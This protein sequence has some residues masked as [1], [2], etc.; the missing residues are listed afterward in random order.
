MAL[1]QQESLVAGLRHQ[2]AAAEDAIATLEEQLEAGSGDPASPGR[3]RNSPA[4][5]A[6]GGRG[7]PGLSDDRA[8]IAAARTRESPLRLMLLAA[9]AANQGVGVGTAVAVWRGQLDGI[10]D[11]TSQLGRR[12]QLPVLGAISAPSPPGQRRRQ[13]RS[14]VEFGLACL[15]L[16]VLFGGLATAEAL[17]LLAPLT[18]PAWV[19][20]AG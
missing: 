19:A 17:D 15:G 9:V 20:A 16:L 12:F 2:L 4:G 13:R 8:A 18:V 14:G 1:G 7:R 11:S 6:G 3:P 5:G 10:V